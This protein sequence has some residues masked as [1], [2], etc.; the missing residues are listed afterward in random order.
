MPR[1]EAAQSA[2]RGLRYQDGRDRRHSEHD[3]GTIAVPDL[4]ENRRRASFRTW[5]FAFVR[6]ERSY[7]MM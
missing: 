3:E 1:D 7:I 2:L 6:T 4:S 5:R